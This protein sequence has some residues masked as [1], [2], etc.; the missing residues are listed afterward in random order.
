MRPIEQSDGSYT[1][2]AADGAVR[3]TMHREGGLSP[4]GDRG[5]PAPGC[6]AASK[7]RGST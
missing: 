7:A 2:H 1:V 6:C 5:S 3:F 4:G